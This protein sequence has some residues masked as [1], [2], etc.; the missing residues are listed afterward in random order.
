MVFCGVVVIGFPAWVF[1]LVEP[2]AGLL[3]V[4]TVR[5]GRLRHQKD[6][7]CD[8]RAGGSHVQRPRGVNRAGFQRDWEMRTGIA[9]R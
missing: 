6:C 7:L 8:C 4:V 3:I 1:V 2:S 5:S 9:V